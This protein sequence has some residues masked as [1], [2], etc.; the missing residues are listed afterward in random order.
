MKLG[1]AVMLAFVLSVA[2]APSNAFSATPGRCDLFS[3][4]ALKALTGLHNAKSKIL[5]RSTRD[6]HEVLCFKYL[7]DGAFTYP[8]YSKAFNAGTFVIIEWTTIEDGSTESATR[9]RR[10]DDQRR[11][12]E[13]AVPV[14]QRFALSTFGAE[15]VLGFF[16]EF[17]TGVAGVWWNA[18]IGRMLE[19]DVN[20][21]P[22][23]PWRKDLTKLAKN[24]VPQYL[25]PAT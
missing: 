5:D 21:S 4:S 1:R 17:H 8:R 12:L 3:A 20:E 13:R 9:G 24:A 25:E 22:R 7:Y 15:A 18:S 14:S 6:Y 11:Q 16:A 10:I 23:R 2:V 19:I